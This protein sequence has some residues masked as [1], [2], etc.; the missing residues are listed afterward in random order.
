[1]KRRRKPPY[2]INWI[3][4][5]VLF[6]IILSVFYGLVNTVLFS[7]VIEDNYGNAMPQEVDCKYF[8]RGSMIALMFL[9]CGV[10]FI[11]GY[12]I[13]GWLEIETIEE[14]GQDEK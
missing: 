8:T 7:N 13:H 3:I 9:F 14:I 5:A 6:I 2:W 4:S 10:S 12:V 1:M 11:G